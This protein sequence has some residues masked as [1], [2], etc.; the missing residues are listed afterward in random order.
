MTKRRMEEIRTY[1][2][3]IGLTVNIIIALRVF[4]IV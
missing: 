3:L 2:F 4:H 1:G